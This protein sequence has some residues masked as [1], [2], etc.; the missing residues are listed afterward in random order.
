[1]GNSGRGIST[2]F[3]EEWLMG[4]NLA[5]YA[6]QLGNRDEARHW[7]ELAYKR[8][9]KLDEGR[10]SKGQAKQSRKQS[11]G[12]HENKAEVSLKT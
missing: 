1:V 7:L 11:R 12:G 4:Y 9:H 8:G 5:C 2:R 6:C 3:P 10:G